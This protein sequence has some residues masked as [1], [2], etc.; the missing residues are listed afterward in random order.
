MTGGP[1]TEKGVGQLAFRTEGPCRL[2][3]VLG[4]GNDSQSHP[5]VEGCLM[6]VNLQPERLPRWLPGPV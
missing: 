3:V 6:R 5:Q 1:G 2:Q 4:T